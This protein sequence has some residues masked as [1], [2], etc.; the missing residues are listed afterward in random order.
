MAQLHVLDVLSV[1]ALFLSVAVIIITSNRHLKQNSFIKKQEIAFYSLKRFSD[2]LEQI[3]YVDTQNK[4]KIFQQLAST[5]RKILIATLKASDNKVITSKDIELYP[6]LRAILAEEKNIDG[7]ALYISQAISDL[8]CE[9][10]NI[11][12]EKNT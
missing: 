6:L 5:E 3:T 8:Q 10:F 4:K 7:A 2:K 1:F 12:L 9:V 11:Y